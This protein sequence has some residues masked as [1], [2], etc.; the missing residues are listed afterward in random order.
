MSAARWILLGAG[1]LILL[2]AGA[3]LVGTALPLRHRATVSEV[4]RAPP[5]QVWAAVTTVDSFPRWRRGVESV[6]RLPERNGRPVWVER[7]RTAPM[8]MEA[9]ELDPP[10]RLVTRIA[11]EELPFGGT[12]T[13]ELEPEGPDTRVTLTENGEIR[14]PLFRFM[15]RFVFGYEHTMRNYLEDLEGHLGRRASG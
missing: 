9:V 11:D 1:L 6:E 15:S 13:F 7:S 8:T 10:R 12:W 5:E 4:V 2:V 14:N 3:Y